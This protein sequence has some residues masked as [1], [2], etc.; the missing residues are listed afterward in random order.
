MNVKGK[1]NQIQALKGIAFLGVFLS[2]T[3]FTCFWSIGH[4]GVSVF[5]V[6]SG[7]MMTYSYYHKNRITNISL[8]DNILFAWKKIRNLY[9][10][11]IITMLTML[12]FAFIGI[13][14]DIRI[15]IPKILLNILLLQEWFPLENASINGVSWYLST[16]VF[17]YFLFPIILKKIENTKDNKNIMNHLIVLLL[18]QVF[19]CKA[20]MFIPDNLAYFTE[21]NFLLQNVSE[22][23]IYFFPLTRCIDFI[24]GCLTGCL[25]ICNRGG[26]TFI[27]NIYQ[28]MTLFVIVVLNCVCVLYEYNLR[29]SLS[30]VTGNMLWFTYSAIF[31][32]SS[33]FLI[34]FIMTKKSWIANLLTQK[35]LLL[36][37]NISSYAFLIH[38]VV[39]R[40]IQAFCCH[41]FD[42]KFYDLYGS[43]IKLTIG[44]ILTILFTNLWI[45]I[46]NYTSKRL[47]YKEIINDENK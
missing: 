13:K 34:Y 21:K 35:L 38:Y 47:N 29:S 2:H 28:Y 43:S 22:W 5:L 15:L 18:I 6:L 31:T 23:L 11:H 4:W 45:Y 16:A 32:F 10:L 12:V 42:R 17:T 27:K 9:L 33:V 20:I 1:L 8:K 39:F 24:I 7:F 14:S 44:F 30:Y 36:L 46:E 40:Y 25:F 41:F 3:G 19:I 26:Q 37:G